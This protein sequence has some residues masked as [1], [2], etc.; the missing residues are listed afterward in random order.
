M[1]RLNL[2]QGRR[3]RGTVPDEM[4]AEG[5]VQ[6]HGQNGGLGQD[7]PPEIGEEGEVNFNLLY[8]IILGFFLCP[9]R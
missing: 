3:P 6:E 8:L 2:P 9:F 7:I 4:D 5:F 1:D